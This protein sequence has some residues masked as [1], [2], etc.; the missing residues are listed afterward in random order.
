M[1]GAAQ[2]LFQ[3]GKPASLQLDDVCFVTEIVCHL[4]YMLR[5]IPKMDMP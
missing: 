5:G 2:K 3:M 4:L 1:E